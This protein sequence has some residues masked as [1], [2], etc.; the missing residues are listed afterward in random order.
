[1][2]GG[3]KSGIL[4]RAKGAMLRTMPLMITCREFED[5]I[6]EYCEGSLPDRQKFIFELHMRVCRECRDYLAAYRQ[7]IE[8]TRRLFDDDRPEL[9]DAVPDELVEAVLAARKA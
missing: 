4:R 5:F 9:P 2:S 7:T 1:M 3:R 6:L 8:V